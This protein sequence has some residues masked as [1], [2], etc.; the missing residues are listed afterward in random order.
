MEE[1]NSSAGTAA[2]GMLLAFALVLGYVET[3]LPFSLGI[4]GAKLGLANLA[5]LLAL[6]MIGGRAAFL[7]NVLRIVLNGFLFGNLYGILYSLAGGVFSFCAMV[8][9]KRFGR[10][11]IP[12]VSICGGIFHN[13]GQLVVAAF[14]VETGGL[15]YYV[16]ALLIAGVATGMAIGIVAG[17]V[18]RHTCKNGEDRI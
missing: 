15:F 8:T 5:V 9:A 11:G 16:P 1:K 17:Q 13:M 4:P 12:G 14:V 18:L 7:L 10:F 3:L 2:L 6:Y